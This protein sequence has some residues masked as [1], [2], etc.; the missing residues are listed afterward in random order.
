M[1]RVKRQ[2]CGDSRPAWWCTTTALQELASHPHL[3]NANEALAP[4]DR[5]THYYTGRKDYRQLD[6]L[7]IGRALYERAGRP[8]PV[9]VRQGLPRRAE[10]YQG[11]RFEGVGD[12][13]PKASYHCPI[14]LTLPVSA[15]R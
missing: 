14:T 7:W 2:R 9:V 13:Q 4:G 3:V 8:A 10:R 6:F 15:L 12:N 11:P 5:W 1:T